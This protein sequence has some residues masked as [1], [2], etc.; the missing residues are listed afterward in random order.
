MMSSPLVPVT[1]EKAAS[2]SIGILRSHDVFKALSSEFP[3]L[4]PGEL[5]K[6]TSI[7]VS[8]EF[9][10]EVNVR[11]RDP[12][13]AA[14]IA[15]RFPD[16]LRD[17]HRS[18]IKSHMDAVAAGARRELIAIES[19][20]AAVQ[21]RYS[22]GEDPFSRAEDAYAL[23][24]DSPA[25]TPN[26]SVGIREGEDWEALDAT[27]Y[28]GLRDASDRLRVVLREAITQSREPSAPIVVVQHPFP[29]DRPVFPLPVLN[30]VVAGLAGTALGAYYA[31]FLGF[32][33][34]LRLTTAVTR[35]RATPGVPAAELESLRALP[36]GGA[37]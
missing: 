8:R 36:K 14:K 12:V 25:G 33:S 22:E 30:T 21:T 3:E 9:M 27:T 16:L 31:L 17:F 1:E 5:Q 35:R 13:R 20:L 19:R 15:A 32:L 26:E 2:I 4:T 23:Y 34:R 29:G 7:E 18:Q 28:Q 10:V 37:P 6:N 24:A 11:D